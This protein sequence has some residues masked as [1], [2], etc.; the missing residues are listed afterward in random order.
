MEQRLLFGN[1]GAQNKDRA[2]SLKV[3]VYD[4]GPEGIMYANLSVEFIIVFSLC[5][6]PA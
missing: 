2:R 5:I 3:H 6:L 4:S 1:S